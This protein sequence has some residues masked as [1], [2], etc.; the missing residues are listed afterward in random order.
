MKTQ[1]RDFIRSLSVGTGMFFM[2]PVTIYDREAEQKAF[3]INKDVYKKKKLETDFLIAGGGMSG[4]C[5]AIAAARNGSKVVLIHNRS[6]LG[7]NAS[8]EI[9]MHISGASALQQVWRETG[10]LEELVLTEA[11]ENPQRSYEMWDF[12]MYNKVVSEENIT[13]LLDT[14]F[15]DL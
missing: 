9:R 14:T 6:R 3:E 2:D 10:I 4:V 7:G 13:L 5:A 1:R 15:Y 8:S 11:V 12:V